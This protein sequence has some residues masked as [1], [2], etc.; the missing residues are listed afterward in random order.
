MT[1]GDAKSNDPTAKDDAVGDGVAV[2][3]EAGRDGDSG[4]TGG[5]SVAG[6]LEAGGTACPQPIAMIK[7]AATARDLRALTMVDGRTR[8]LPPRC[9]PQGG[10][11]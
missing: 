6:E 11:N 3:L 10:G 2:L 5:A 7:A 8:R 9:V 1:S 4:V